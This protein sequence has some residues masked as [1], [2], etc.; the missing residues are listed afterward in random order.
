M[1]LN[2]TLIYTLVV[3]LALALVTGLALAEI[4]DRPDMFR[5]NIS[6]T[7]DQETERANINHM[8]FYVP[9]QTSDGL[10][11]A[12]VYTDADGTLLNEIT[13]S[14]WWRSISTACRTKK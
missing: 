7:P 6:K 8:A 2:K 12:V 10:F 13:P 14:R 1:K 4:G 5:R 11:P 3:L 9:A